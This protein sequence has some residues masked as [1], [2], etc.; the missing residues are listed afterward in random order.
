MLNARVP[1]IVSAMAALGLV[2]SGC[3]MSA[4]PPQATSSASDGECA[5]VRVIVDFTELNQEGIDSCVTADEPMTALAALNAAGVSVTG[6]DAAGDN[7]MCRV[8]GRPAADEELRTDTQGPFTEDCA[9][10]GSG[11]AFWSL[12]LDAGDGWQ[13]ANEGVATQPVNPGESIGI[14]WQLTDT[15]ADMDTWLK[16]NV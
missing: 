4:S 12:F 16:P 13:S 1:F 15:A 9:A 7:W 5:G 11:W 6:S 14:V 2:L 10:Y 3:S 8:D